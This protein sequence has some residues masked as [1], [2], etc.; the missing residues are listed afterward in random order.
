MSRRN[1]TLWF[2][3]TVRNLRYRPCGSQ[4]NSRVIGESTAIRAESNGENSEKLGVKEGARDMGDYLLTRF[5][6]AS[7]VAKI[8]FF[9]LRALRTFMEGCEVS[10]TTFACSPLATSITLT[11]FAH[12]TLGSPW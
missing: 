8:Y 1:P 5:S 3:L 11:T 9:R 4:E 7:R 10:K 6:L 2:R 12:A